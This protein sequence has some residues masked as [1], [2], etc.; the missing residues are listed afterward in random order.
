MAEVKIQKPNVLVIMVDQWNHRCLSFKG[1]PDVKTPNLDRLRKDSVDFTRCYVQNS[2]CLPSRTSYLTGQYLFHHRQYGFT[3]L[4]PEDTPCI[5][6]FF[7]DHGY[8]TCHVGKANVN[9]MMDILGFDTFIPTLPEDMCF[10]TDPEETYQTYCRREGY[11]FPTDQ[12]HGAELIPP[13][14]KVRTTHVSWLPDSTGTSHIPLKDSPEAYTMG[15]ALEWLDHRPK[16]KPFFLHVSFDRPHPPLTPSE[17]Y[18]AVVDPESLTIPPPY[19]EEQ[20]AKLPAHLHNYTKSRESLTIMGEE[21]MRNTLA[22]YYGLM[23]HIDHEIGRIV[24]S[25]KERGI[26]EET[27]ILFYSDHGD[28]AGYK[29]LFNKYSNTVFHDDII[30]T[31]MLIKLVDQKHE[32]KAVGGLSE[33]IDVFPTLAG[34]CGLDCAALKLDGMDLRESIRQGETPPE[35]AAF[36]ESY[37]IKVLIRGDWKLV[38][39][40]NSSEGELYNLAEDPDERVNRF[41]DLS[42]RAVVEGMEVGIIKKMT[43][44][45]SER[46]K[47][48]VRSLFDDSDYSRYGFMEKLFKWERSIIEGGGFWMVWRDGYRLTYLPFDNDLRFEKIDSTRK[49]VNQRLGLTQSEDVAVREGMIRELINFLSTKTRPISVITGGQVHWDNMLQSKGPGLC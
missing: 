17:P 44:P 49:V 46:R 11:E 20:A 48:F 39:Y 32:G 28:M 33:A 47:A 26:Y 4:M 34:L 15:K 14:F 22:M 9:P 13:A 8:V 40:V 24:D 23:M 35:R 10:A 1:H 16:E 37:G 27:I 38:H 18:D 30:R 5:S 25:L 19:T 41:S 31:P 2:I 3:G 6:A 36:S 42:C 12:V 29:G 21:N 45:V 43:A 7:R